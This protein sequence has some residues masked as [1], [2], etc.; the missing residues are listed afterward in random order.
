MK[1]TVGHPEST[2]LPRS[3]DRMDR[4]DTNSPTA[5]RALRIGNWYTILCPALS[6]LRLLS[7]DHREKLA[8]ANL[9]FQCERASNCPLPR[10]G[11][12]LG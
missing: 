5:R 4:M 9:L 6:T 2:S 1:A 7:P 8:Q 11:R 12:I 10:S 3:V